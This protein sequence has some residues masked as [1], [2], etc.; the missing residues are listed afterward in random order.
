MTIRSTNI[1]I[2]ILLMLLVGQAGAS[3]WFKVIDISP[4]SMEPNSIAN[5]TVSVKGMGS[6]G[7]YVALVFRNVSEGLGI[8]CERK[9]KYVFP[10]GTT[11]YNCTIE[12]AD[13][14]P[15]NYS[16][17]VDVAARGSPSGRMT[18]YVDVVSSAAATMEQEEAGTENEISVDVA[19]EKFVSSSGEDSEESKSQGDQTGGLEKSVPRSEI[20]IEIEPEGNQAP[21]L[22]AVPAVLAL[23][24]VTRR[25]KR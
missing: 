23:L 17:V 20:G 14:P 25:M 21:G 12:V 3:L 5:F 24:I 8:S 18:G 19:T 2:L 10:A 6:E 13:I 15:G 7:A 16:F 4:I 22:G 9:T 1:V 11:E